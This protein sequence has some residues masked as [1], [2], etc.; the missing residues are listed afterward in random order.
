MRWID[1][2][3]YYDNSIT[4]EVA[5]HI[6]WDE[7]AFPFSDL[8]YTLYQIRS[9]IRTRKNKI[10]RCEM[11]GNKIPFHHHNCMELIK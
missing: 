11:C 7:T 3:Q 1:F 4:H 10:N 8:R 6:L 9:A 2:M 5:E